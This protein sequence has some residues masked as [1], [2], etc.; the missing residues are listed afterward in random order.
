MS[1]PPEPQLIDLASGLLSR[2]EAGEIMAHV[3]ACPECEARLR[4]MVA[5]LESARSG[6]VPVLVDGRIQLAEHRRRPNILIRA[7]VAAAVIAAIVLGTFLVVNRHDAIPEYWIPV[8][9]GTTT[10]HRGTEPGDLADALSSYQGHDAASAIE[11]LE[12]IRPAPDDNTSTR[13]RDLYLASALINAGRANE[14]LEVLDRNEIQ[15]MP[16]PWRY[17]AEWVKY[18]GLRRAGRDDEAHKWLET[19]ATTPGENRARAQSELN[20]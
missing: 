18:V 5:D 11:Q 1:H 14:G 4:A 16:T 20:R 7:S 10:L 6:P 8:T 13:L 15:W 17:E 3:R 12:K 9:N 19:L 2:E